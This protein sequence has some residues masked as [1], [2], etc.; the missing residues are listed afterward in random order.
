MASNRREILH[1][2]IGITLAVHPIR[3]LVA[4]MRIIVAIAAC[5]TRTTLCIGVTIRTV[6]VVANLLTSGTLKPTLRIATTVVAIRIH[7]AD[8]W[9]KVAI[10]SAR[11]TAGLIFRHA[12]PITIAV[13]AIYWSIRGTT[14]STPWIT[15]TLIAIRIHVAGIRII[16]AIARTG[17]RACIRV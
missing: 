7:V 13:V 14:L 5:G 12:M 10:A 3:I 17:F 9:I 15:G 2:A 4:R 11:I 6:A 16:V 8:I 1:E